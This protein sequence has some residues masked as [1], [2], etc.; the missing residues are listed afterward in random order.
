MLILGPKQMVT[1]LM[2]DGTNQHIIA[3]ATGGAYHDGT[4]SPI[5]PRIRLAAGENFNARS[6]WY[7]GELTGGRQQGC[8]DLIDARQARRTGIRKCRPGREDQ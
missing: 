6:D 2:G 3:I 1:Q 7:A 5:R 4:T 8:C